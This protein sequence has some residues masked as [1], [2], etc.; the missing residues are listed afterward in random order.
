MC[1]VHARDKRCGDTFRLATA[2]GD[3]AQ[4]KIR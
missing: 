1:A 2:T 4:I 3:Q